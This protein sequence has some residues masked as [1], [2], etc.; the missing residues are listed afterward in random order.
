MG[1]NGDNSGDR[2]PANATMLQAF[3]WNVPA[4]GKHW[5]RL[6]KAIPAWE[7]M[8]ITNVWIPPACKGGGPDSNGYDI[9]DLYD[10]GEF[11]Q[12]GTVRTKFGTKEEL[13]A[14]SD[15][16]HSRNIGLYFDAVLNHKA[17]ADHTERCRAVEVDK[18]D[19][20][21]E[22][23][24]VH[25]IEAWVGFD[26]EGRGGKYS[27]MKY[28]W[29][30]FSG[31]DYNAETEK[32]AIYA[33][34]K[35]EGDGEKWSGSVD[36]SEKGNFDY[37]MFA[38]VDFDH[39][40]VRND[41]KNWGVWLSK[42]IFLKGIRFDA[43]RHFSASFLK[44]FIAHMKENVHDDWFLV[45]EFWK[46]SYDTMSKYLDQMD[47]NFSLFDVPLVNN[48]SRISREPDADLRAIFDSTLTKN[49]PVNAVTL[50]ANHDTQPGQT[51]ETPIEGWFKPLAY[52]T[53][54]LRVDGYPC[55][56]YGD[57]YGIHDP[58]SG[59]K[60]EPLQ[61]LPMLALARKLYAYG[62]Q[63]EY[64]DEANCV[65]WVRRGTHDRK[66]GCAVVMSNTGEARKRM[67]VGEEH[68]GEVWSDLLGWA[69]DGEVTIGEDGHAEFSCGATS[70][71]VW[72]NKE[73][74]G[75]N[76]VQDFDTNIYEE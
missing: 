15:E 71:S 63:D 50:V 68:K 23:S 21:K 5:Q 9:Y 12:K 32:N 54:L 41:V 52:A 61:P 26:F 43:V 58:E 51:S 7:K 18:E 22:V 46:D 76:G 45:G 3:E 25:E 6:K 60:S 49:K 75:R 34:K 27:D 69:P 19:R 13:V 2:T 67:F 37:L 53:I 56:F 1:D 57:L 47:G 39:P 29:Y 30:H 11:D 14:L 8:G 72:V 48:F 20:M 35:D 55:V 65:G 40:D 36:T 62:A 17:A 64:W 66:D 4:D 44:E 59:S 24:D 16:A 42:Q 10:I 74:E 70:V 38:D 33:I 73:A 28:H 31:T